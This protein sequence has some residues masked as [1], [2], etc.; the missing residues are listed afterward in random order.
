MEYPGLIRKL[1]GKIEKFWLAL[2]FILVAGLSYEAGA[3]G[4]ALDEAK[5]VVVE[6]PAVV[7]PTTLPERSLLVPT[8][9][10]EKTSAP[11]TIES[12]CAF[13]GSKNSNKYHIP[14]SRCAKQIKSEN[15]VCFSSVE[16]ASAKGYI[17]G[18]ME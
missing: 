13:V 16:A 4:E 1:E 3:I 14:T 11:L 10:A 18:C 12:G 5:P 17:S 6:V 8:T 7:P 15:R 2:A 9:A